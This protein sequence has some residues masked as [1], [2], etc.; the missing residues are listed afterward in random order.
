MAQFDVHRNLGA[1]PREIPFVVVVQSQRLDG[2]RRRVVVPLV[3]AGAVRVVEPN[4][5]PTFLVDSVPVVLHPLELVSVPVERLGERVA[6]LVDEGDRII[7]AI[8]IVIS[9]A[10]R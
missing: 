5:N 1:N 7:A 10:W 8:D 6:T 4:L 2:Y 3:A 9:R